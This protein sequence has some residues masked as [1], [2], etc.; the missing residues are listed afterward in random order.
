MMPVLSWSEIT[1]LCD[2]YRHKPGV[3]LNGGES[4]RL[5]LSGM[6][7]SGDGQKNRSL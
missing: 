5:V 1:D 6:G 3:I 2:T 7:V 4:Y